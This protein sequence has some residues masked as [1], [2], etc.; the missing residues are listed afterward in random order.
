MKTTRWTSAM[1]RLQ[2]IGIPVLPR[3]RCLQRWP[4]D[5]TELDKQLSHLFMDNLLKEGRSRE[6]GENQKGS[7]WLQRH[8][9]GQ[10]SELNWQINFERPDIWGLSKTLHTTWRLCRT[11]A[12]GVSSIHVGVSFNCS[13]APFRSHVS[14]TLY[15]TGA[16]PTRTELFFWVK[17][18]EAKKNLL[19]LGFPNFLH[20]SAQDRRA[21]IPS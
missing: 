20:A 13:T 16:S 18:K 8:F 17:H 11:W 3:Y 6:M 9:L 7:S 19:L 15:L 4:E 1:P 21:R 14:K 5:N 12:C 2:L 10:K